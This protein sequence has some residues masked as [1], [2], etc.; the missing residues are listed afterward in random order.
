MRRRGGDSMQ[1]P[2][3]PLEW[4]KNPRSQTAMALIKD[5]ARQNLKLRAIFQAHIEA[6]ICR[7]DGVL[8]VAPDGSRIARRHG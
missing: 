3:D 5:G 1:G 8:L 7:A 4:A 6:G 2:A